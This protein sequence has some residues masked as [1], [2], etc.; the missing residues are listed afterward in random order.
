MLIVDG[1]K[2]GR[3]SQ[4]FI[5]AGASRVVKVEWGDDVIKKKVNYL[6]TVSMDPVSWRLPS[7][8]PS[9]GRGESP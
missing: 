2:W 4:I 3:G 5:F 7:F 9:P 1:E 6:Q 8:G